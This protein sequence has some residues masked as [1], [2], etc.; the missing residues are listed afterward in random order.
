MEH[1][2]IFLLRDSEAREAFC[3]NIYYHF[4]CDKHFLVKGIRNCFQV[5]KHAQS[6]ETYNAKTTYQCFFWLNKVFIL[7]F[8]VLE[9]RGF[10]RKVIE[11]SA[12][13]FRASFLTFSTES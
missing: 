11:V 1:G 8:W 2:K 12:V 3:L 6:S 5:P 4:N 10:M 7:S 9:I 13:I